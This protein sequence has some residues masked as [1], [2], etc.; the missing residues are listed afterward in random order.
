LLD[1]TPLL[2]EEIQKYLHWWFQNNE[3]TVTVIAKAGG[4]SVLTVN[5]SAIGFNVVTIIGRQ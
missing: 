3:E 4:N 1:C 2:L 5:D